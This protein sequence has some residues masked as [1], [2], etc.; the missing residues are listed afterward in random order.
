LT[1]EDEMSNVHAEGSRMV[2]EIPTRVKLLESAPL[3][4]WIALSAD[5]SR[6]V[7]SGKTIREVV[8]LCDKRGEANPTLLK[9]PEAWGPLFL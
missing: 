2:Q 9:T 6:I 5:E 8:E 3:D 7:A 4:S 1:V